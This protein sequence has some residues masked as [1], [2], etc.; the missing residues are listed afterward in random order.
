MQ[1]YKHCNRLQYC[2]ATSQSNDTDMIYSI[3]NHYRGL[4]GFLNREGENK[5]VVNLQQSENSNPIRHA[6][7]YN[8]LQG[9]GNS[10]FAMAD[11]SA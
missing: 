1:G 11:F 4:S 8:R 10:I 5:G 7:P 6:A 3:L 2:I 9:E